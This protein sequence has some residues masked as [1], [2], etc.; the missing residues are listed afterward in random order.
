[1]CRGFDSL[2]G[3]LSSLPQR[4]ARPH[5]EQRSMLLNEA[6]G[7]R[8]SAWRATRATHTSPIET[9]CG[10]LSLCH[11]RTRQRLT[12]TRERCHMMPLMAWCGYL[13]EPD[14]WAALRC[15]FQ[16]LSCQSLRRLSSSGPSLRSRPADADRPDRPW[17]PT[18]LRVRSH[19]SCTST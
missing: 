12:P 5:R 15:V 13:D 4:V 18:S 9:L 11:W 6:G 10:S 19:S 8:S 7:Y 16:V 17:A 3:Y 1:M 14:A 2:L